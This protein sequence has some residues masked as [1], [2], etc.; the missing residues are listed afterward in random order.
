M[1]GKGQVSFITTGRAALTAGHKQTLLLFAIN[2]R[3]NSA[4]EVRITDV[5]LVQKN[6][7]RGEKKRQRR[8]A[9]KLTP[10]GQRSG[11]AECYQ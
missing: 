5:A 11:R 9:E 2:K 8:R 6:A 4:C 7:S 1:D 3:V 10:A